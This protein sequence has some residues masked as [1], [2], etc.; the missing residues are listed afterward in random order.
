MALI[1]G[2]FA[3]E[4]Q[5]TAIAVAGRLADL[6]PQNKTRRVYRELGLR[7]RNKTRE[8]RDMYLPS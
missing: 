7:L 8:R 4:P 2:W 1:E 5:L 3:A 6:H